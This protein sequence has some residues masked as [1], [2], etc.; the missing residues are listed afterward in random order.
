M[1][2]GELGD[3]PLTNMVLRCAIV[4]TREEKINRFIFID[5]GWVDR[6]VPRE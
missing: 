3:I 1:H 6:I 4:K 2:D 5:G